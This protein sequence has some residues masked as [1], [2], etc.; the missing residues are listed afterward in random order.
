MRLLIPRMLLLPNIADSVPA[1]EVPT[2]DKP[3]P[4]RSPLPPSVDA[5]ASARTSSPLD[6]EARC[7]VC[8]RSGPPLSITPPA[9]HDD[10]DD[11]DDVITCSLASAARALVPSLVFARSDYCIVVTTALRISDWF[12]RS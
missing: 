12:R 6:T 5:A 9:C 8:F 1:L 3:S 2:E 4:S 10:D 7:N 11:D